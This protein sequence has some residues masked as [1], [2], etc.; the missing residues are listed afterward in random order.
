MA[1]TRKE[2]VVDAVTYDDTNLFI[3]SWDCNGVEAIINVTDEIRDNMFEQ[4]KGKYDMGAR[5]GHH[6]HMLTMRARF[7]PQRYYEIYTIRT[8]PELDTETMRK[9]FEDMPQEMADLIRERGVR[10]M[11]DR[12]TTSIKIV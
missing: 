3:I 8:D 4:L 7:N 2:R 11:S 12:R 5:L 10:V 1:K 9:M 6:L